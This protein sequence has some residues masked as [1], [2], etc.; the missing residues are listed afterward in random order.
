MLILP[1][2]PYQVL[3]EDF[4]FVVVAVVI[5]TNLNLYK[6]RNK[7]WIEEWNRLMIKKSTDNIN[8]NSRIN[9]ENRAMGV[10]NLFWLSENVDLHA[11]YLI[12]MPVPLNMLLWRC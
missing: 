1:G 11:K 6:T 8:I 9:K 4:I 7:G 10:L 3:T 5:F 12:Y 2:D